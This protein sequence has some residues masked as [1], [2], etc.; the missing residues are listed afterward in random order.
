MFARNIENAIYGVVIFAVLG[1]GTILGTYL[2]PK[3]SVDHT[4]YQK[5]FEITEQKTK[6]LEA[7]KNEFFEIQKKVEAETL[8][9]QKLEA[10][11]QVKTN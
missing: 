9:L 8:E 3:K 2:T 10:Q 6:E 11:A 1:A 7:K 5:Q 4:L